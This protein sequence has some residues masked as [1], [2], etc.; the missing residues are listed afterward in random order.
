MFDGSKVKCPFH[1]RMEG[2]RGKVMAKIRKRAGGK[3]ALKAI[4]AFLRASQSRG[5]LKP[6]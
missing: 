4:G 1:N 6:Q 3:R 5:Y 2:N